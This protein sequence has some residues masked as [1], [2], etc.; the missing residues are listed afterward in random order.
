MPSEALIEWTDP[1]AE[2]RVVVERLPSGL[3]R[4]CEEHFMTV[5]ETADGGGIYDYWS[6]VHFSGL[7][8]STLDAQ[9][10]AA[11]RL[12][13]LRVLLDGMASPG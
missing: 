12:P 1:D 8:P 7:Y 9:N 6:T 5:D 11:R 3:Y 2:R 4:Y 10:D 13:W